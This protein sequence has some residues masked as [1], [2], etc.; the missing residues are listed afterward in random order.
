MKS[1]S[2]K[3]LLI[4]C[5]VILFLLISIPFISIHYFEVNQNERNYERLQ[6]NHNLVKHLLMKKDFNDIQHIDKYLKLRHE[7]LIIIKNK[8]IVFSNKSKYWVKKILKDLHYHEK[9]FYTINNQSSLEYYYK[10]YIDHDYRGNKL[11]IFYDI[12][13]YLFKFKVLERGHDVYQYYIG[14]DEKLNDDSLEDVFGENMHRDI[15][16]L[17]IILFLVLFVYGFYGLQ[18]FTRP[19]KTIL[20]DIKNLKAQKDMSLRIDNSYNNEEFKIIATSFNQMLDEIERDVKKIT[21]LTITDGLTKLYNRRH[22]DTVFENEFRRARRNK[23]NLVISIFDLDKFKQYNDVYGHQKG[24]EALEAVAQ[25]LRNNTKRANDSAFRIGGEEFAI[26]TSDITEDK[27]KLYF[28]KLRK[29]IEYNKIPHEKNE[30][31]EYL[32]ASFGVVIVDFDKISSDDNLTASKLYKITDDMLYN[33][34]EINRN[35][36]KILNYTS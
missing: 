28:E 15:I 12:K 9:T 4:Y 35:M 17:S 16:L 25:T 10:D 26:I 33:A 8:K 23:T 11:K 2:F 27:I 7:F 21:E 22:F 30:A 13:H 1:I 18:I 14:T 20:K 3:L 19:A 34:K 24:D 5:S 36:V 32:T 29:A 6:E 31:S